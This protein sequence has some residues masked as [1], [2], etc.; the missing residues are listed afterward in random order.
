MADRYFEQCSGLW[1]LSP[2]QRAENDRPAQN[3]LGKSFRRVLQ[4]DGKYSLVT[5]ICSKTD[6]VSNDDMAQASPKDSV[7]RSL[8]Q[9]VEELK[10]KIHEAYL[11]V[12]NLRD[13]YEAL[14][15]E[16]GESGDEMDEM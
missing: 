4:L 13:G 6:D 1:C 12:S 7:L 14:R 11:E 15:E 5:F 2:I 10:D 8:S 16:L 3:L 9:E